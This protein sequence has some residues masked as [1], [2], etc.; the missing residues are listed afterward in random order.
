MPAPRSSA[1]W[2]ST[3]NIPP[4]TMS[5]S[6][7]A[8]AGS[9]GDW[10]IAAMAA[11]P[12][13]GRRMTGALRIRF[14]HY[15]SGRSSTTC[16]AAWCRW[17]CFCCCSAPGWPSPA[18]A[19][20]ARRR[21]SWI[22]A[23]PAVLTI[24][25]DC[26]PQ[27]D[28]APLAGAPARRGRGG[29]PAVR[30]DLPHARL[31]ALRRLRQP[32][33]DRADAGAHALTRQPPPGMADRRSDSEQASGTDLAGFLRRMWVAPAVA[34]LGAAAYWR[35]G[36]RPSC[37][38]RSRILGALARRPGIAWWISR[39]DRARAPRLLRGAGGFPPGNR[40]QDLAF[41]RDLCHRRGKLAS[42][43]QFP[44]E[45][46]API[47][48]SRTSPT[49]MGLALLA[50]LA[51]RDFGYLSVGRL[52]ERTER[53]LGHDAAPGALPRALLQ[54]V[55]HRARCSPLL[56]LYVSSVDSGNLAG[57]LL[58]LGSGLEGTG[59]PEDPSAAG[60]CRAARH[61]WRPASPGRRECGAEPA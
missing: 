15:R 21:W 19:S 20:W 41:F 16:G 23:L 4:A 28:R 2:S 1:T 10:Q 44:G 26:P 45:S 33:C 37:L 43:R 27:A 5:T 49:N 17:P 50:N 18:W 30:P 11:A 29:G 22:I 14:R 38:R 60:F 6:A 51:A 35:A 57:H 7:G 55:R 58:T 13:A 32:G 48:A 53:R 52:I 54:L 42:A 12:G 39:A 61:R 24:L 46:R 3:R 31:P 25:V 56:P 34:L 40:P 36:S 9:A 59:R 8:T 47:I